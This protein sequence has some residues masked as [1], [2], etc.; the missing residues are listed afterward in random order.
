MKKILTLPLLLAFA[1]ASAQTMT[2]ETLWSLGRVGAN[3][4][5]PDGTQLVY[6]VTV[7]NIEN[8][9]FDKQTYALNLASA[10]V[11]PIEKANEVLPMAKTSPVGD[12]RLTHRGVKIKK[13]TGE[14]YYPK[15]DKSDVKIYNNLHYRHWDH[16]EDGKYNHVFIVDAAGDSTDIMA[17][18]AFDSPTVPFGGAEDYIWTPDGKAVIYVC[19]KLFGTEYVNS[20]NTDLYRYDLATGQTTNL[21]ADNPGYDTDCLAFDGPRRV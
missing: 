8:N 4:I 5:S 20:T 2:P 12:K 14:D 17:G 6:T 13:V 11:K 9:D 1:A 15:L 3:G 21:T 7:P 18:E 16:W 10:V 19:K